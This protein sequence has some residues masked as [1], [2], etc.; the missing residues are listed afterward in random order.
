MQWFLSPQGKMYRGK[1]A[2]LK[3]IKMEPALF[4]QHEVNIF[5]SVPLQV[6]T[7]L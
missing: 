4:K 5:K 6:S 1:K 7:N 3:H 2:V